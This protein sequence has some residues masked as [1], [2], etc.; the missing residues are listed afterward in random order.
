MKALIFPGQGSQNLSMGKECMALDERY[1]KY[2]DIANEIL[3][4]DIKSIIFGEDINQLTLTE[5]AQPAILIC[6]YIKYIH[7]ESK[8]LN[9]KALAGHSLGEWTALV[10]SGV[11]SFEEAVEAVHSRGLFMSNACEPNKGS[12]AAV[13][14]MKIEEIEKILN[15]YDDVII[16]NYNS[17]MQTVI[18]GETEQLL[19]SMDELK[20]NGAK[21]IIKL[22]VSGPFHSHLLNKAEENMRIK[23]EKINFK[24]PKIPIVQNVNA[25]FEIDPYIIK[26]NIIKQITRPVKW[27]ESIENMKENGIDEFIEIGP[28]KVLSK[29]IKNILMDVK[30]EY[31]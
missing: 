5:N 20:E 12:M 21:R 19:K 23:L 10:V 26:E 16:A 22:N 31:V 11:I 30:L 27:V 7:N 24:T 14:G 13:L 1:E 6:S 3:N 29:M 4:F 15:N 8:Y 2:F 28:S 25:K 18:S 17:P 9:I